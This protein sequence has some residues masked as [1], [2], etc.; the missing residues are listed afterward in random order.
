MGRE[1]IYANSIS[2]PW[3]C[4]LN[5]HARQLTTECV[6]FDHQELATAASLLAAQNFDAILESPV[7][8]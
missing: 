7:I 5:R 1:R 6:M 8:E 4:R 2:M 3:T